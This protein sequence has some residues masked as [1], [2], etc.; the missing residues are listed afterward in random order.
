[1]ALDVAPLAIAKAACGGFVLG[2]GAGGKVKIFPPR[3]VEEHEAVRNLIQEL[4][5]AADS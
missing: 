1:M 2:G 3:D 5:K 4:V